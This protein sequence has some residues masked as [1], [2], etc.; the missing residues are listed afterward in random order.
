MLCP[1]KGEM[2]NV[3]EILAGKSEGRSLGKPTH[4]CEMILNY[5]LWT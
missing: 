2:R 3:Y 4:K 1:R 5:V